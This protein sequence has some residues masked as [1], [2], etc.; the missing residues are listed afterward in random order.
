[1]KNKK[2]EEKSYMNSENRTLKTID[3][4]LQ[5][6]YKDLEDEWEEISMSTDM[7]KVIG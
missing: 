2:Q 3:E 1:M 4:N 5:L 7:E 6:T